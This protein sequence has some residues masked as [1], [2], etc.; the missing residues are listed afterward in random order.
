MFDPDGDDIW[1][2]SPFPVRGT[3]YVERAASSY[4]TFQSPFPVR[5]TTTDWRSDPEAQLVSIP[6]PREG[7]DAVLLFIE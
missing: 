6:V 3:T 4:D 5:G 1:F 7:N 2:Q